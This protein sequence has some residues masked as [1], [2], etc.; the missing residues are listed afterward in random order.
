MDSLWISPD[1][2]ELKRTPVEKM[3]FARICYRAGIAADGVCR[4]SNPELASAVCIHPQSVTDLVKALAKSGLLTSDPNQKK[5]NKREITPIRKFLTPY[6]ERADRYKEK[7]DSKRSKS[8]PAD[9]YKEI[10]D[11]PS[12]EFP[13]SPGELQGNSLEG[14]SQILGGYKEIP[15]SLYKDTKPYKTLENLN[16]ENDVAA[17]DC[18]VELEEKK[19]QALTPSSARP[20]SPKPIPIP[21]GKVYGDGVLQADVVT[22]YTQFPDQFPLHIYLPFLRYWTSKNQKGDPVQIGVEKWRTQNQWD[23]EIRLNSWNERD[24]KKALE[25]QPQHGNQPATNP[26]GY[27]GSAHANRYGSADYE[28]AFNLVDALAKAGGL[29]GR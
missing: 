13:Y 14:I 27:T 25:N 22:Y 15:D 24:I 28:T 8:A 6:K 17:N 26:N 18:F 20:P 5:G 10:P 7:T 16:A 9:D 12:K 3:L 1:I 11:S 19:G 23:I 4:D 2:M 21:A 29:N